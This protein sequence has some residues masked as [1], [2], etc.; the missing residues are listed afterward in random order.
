[1]W[2]LDLDQ[3]A[4]FIENRDKYKKENVWYKKE[5]SD[6]DAEYVCRWAHSDGLV[7]NRHVFIFGGINDQNMAMRS[8]FAYDFIENKFYKLSES[9]DPAP[10]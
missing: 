8:T 3:I 2:A 6:E 4:N 10:T 9:G 1:V 5:L 7:D